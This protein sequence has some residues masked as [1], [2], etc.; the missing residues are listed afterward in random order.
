MSF[1]AGAIVGRL[2]LNTGQFSAGLSGA[3]KSVTAF[4]A[5]F[6]ALGAKVA[7]IGLA[8][9]GVAGVAGIGLLVRSSANAIDSVGKL[10]DRLGV[11]TEALIS[12][13]HQAGLAGVGAEELTNGIEHFLRTSGDAAKMGTEAALAAVA[14]RIAAMENPAQR[15]RAATEAFGRAGQGLLPMLMQ[16]SAGIAAARAEA[17][18]LG[19]TFSRVDAAQ[20]E[21][22]NDAMSRMRSVIT[23]VGQQL[24]IKLAPFVEAAA[25][26]LTDLGTRGRGAA[27]YVVDGFEWVVMAVAKTSDTLNLLKAGFY[28]WRAAVLQSVAWVVRGIDSVGSGLAKL[29]NMLPGVEV[30]WS[31]T[32]GIMAA[33]L[34]IVAAEQAGLMDEAWGHFRDGTTSK[35]VA[36]FF[37]RMRSQSRQSAEAVAAAGAKMN[38]ALVNP[39]LERIE[40]AMAAIRLEVEQFGMS[41]AAKRLAELGSLGADAEQ[42]AQAQQMLGTLEAM[43][44]ARERQAELELRAKSVMEAVR[45]PLESYEAKIGE[46]NDLVEAGAISWE[47]YGRAVRQARGKLEGAGQMDLRGPELIRSGSAEAVRLAYELSTGS[48]GMN[49]EEVPKKQLDELK[50][51]SRTLRSIDRAVGQRVMVEI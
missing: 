47:I 42:L 25:A 31:G 11:T 46:L 36:S 28:A 32:L 49:K 7:G 19:I 27:G 14:D 44:K 51:A 16:G 1:D 45:T 23:G 18:K 33:G 38:G 35:A 2:V 4:G 20:V 10:S 37:E 8:L 50:A 12:L 6:A 43:T 9:G 13:R 30:S 21:A 48:R 5:K 3:A 34:E 24:A 15:A 41:D 39:N 22:A 29:L 40:E 17:E 26:K